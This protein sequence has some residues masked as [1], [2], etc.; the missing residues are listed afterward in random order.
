MVTGR[1]CITET[2]GVREDGTTLPVLLH[3]FPLLERNGRVM[4]FIELVEDISQR[5]KAERALRDSEALLRNI[6]SA[7]PDLLTVHDRDR[8]VVLSNWH[9]YESVPLQRA[10]GQ[11]ATATPATNTGKNPARNAT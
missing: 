5:R 1:P 11:A 3:A 4:G 7:I 10:T 2:A 6:F 8:R 9:G